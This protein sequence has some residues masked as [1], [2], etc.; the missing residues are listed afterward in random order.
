MSSI[1]LSW[2]STRLE[3]IPV[4]KEENFLEGERFLL[5]KSQMSFVITK[6]KS[7]NHLI[8]DEVEIR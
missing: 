4:D 1:S 6:E 3:E 5:A 2:H 7:S 8:S